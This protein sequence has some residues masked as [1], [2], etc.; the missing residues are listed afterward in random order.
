MRRLVMRHD[1]KEFHEHFRKAFTKDLMRHNN[2]R[3]KHQMRKGILV[4]M[5]SP[6]DFIYGLRYLIR[7]KLQKDQSRDIP[8]RYLF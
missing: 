5:T 3:Y 8:A 4:R 6:D 7:R 1:S 2:I